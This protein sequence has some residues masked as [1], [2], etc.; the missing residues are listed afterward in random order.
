MRGSD[1]P[2]AFEMLKLPYVSWCW[3]KQLDTRPQCYH[4]VSCCCR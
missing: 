1:A 2:E 4:T 3:K